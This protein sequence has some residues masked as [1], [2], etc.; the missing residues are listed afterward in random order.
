MAI[1]TVELLRKIER[2][3]AVIASRDMAARDVRMSDA[4]RIALTELLPRI[5]GAL[6]DYVFAVGDLAYL[7]D[8]REIV[9]RHGAKSLGKLFAR[10][11]G[12]PVGDFMVVRV[13]GG[14]N[15]VLWQIRQM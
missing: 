11:A 5:H 9:E 2:H 4:D 3:L 10:T 15:G 12:A 1:E 6:K 13:S 7:D 14:R 8:T